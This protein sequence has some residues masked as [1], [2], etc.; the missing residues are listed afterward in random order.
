[1]GEVSLI[2]ACSACTE[3][4]SGLDVNVEV[5]GRVREWDVGQ[6]RHPLEVRAHGGLVG[7]I[8]GAAGHD[9]IDQEGEADTSH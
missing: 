5:F 7:I 1:M 8:L 2:L 9:Q 6:L 3:E 4:L